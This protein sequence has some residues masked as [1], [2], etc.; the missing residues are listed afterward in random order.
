M[1]TR[2]SRPLAARQAASCRVASRNTQSPIAWIS[3]A[4]SASGMNTAGL[5]SPR[6]GCAQRSSASTRWICPVAKSTM[7]W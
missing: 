6:P 7:G 2:S 1:L 5:T 3:P 4:S